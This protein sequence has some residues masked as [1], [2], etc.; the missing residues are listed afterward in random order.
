MTKHSNRTVTFGVQIV[1]VFGTEF[2]LHGRQ[3]CIYK[4]LAVCTYFSLQNLLQDT[5]IKYIR[6]VN[7]FGFRSHFISFFV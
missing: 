7:W 5:Q 1:K 4:T 6:L 3:F 2:V